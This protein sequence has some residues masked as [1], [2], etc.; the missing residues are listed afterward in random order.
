MYEFY[1]L[2]GRKSN[3]SNDKSKD[4]ERS[5]KDQNGSKVCFRCGRIGHF[6]A[7]CPGKDRRV[8][9]VEAEDD[10]EIVE[11]DDNSSSNDKQ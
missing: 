4:K 10:D 8:N 6:A 7:V 3:Y 5:Q 1:K 2:W 9:S 11:N